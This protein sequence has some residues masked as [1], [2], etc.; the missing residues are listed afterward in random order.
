LNFSCK[1]DWETYAGDHIDS[2]GF[3]ILNLKPIIQTSDKT[4]IN[5][6]V[7]DDCCWEYYGYYYSDEISKTLTLGVIKPE[8]YEE[9]PCECICIYTLSFKIDRGFENYKIKLE[10]KGLKNKTYP[11][12]G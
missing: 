5:V 12:N 1:C 6:L 4:E 3:R 9:G 11:N 2:L 10:E 8:N 7:I